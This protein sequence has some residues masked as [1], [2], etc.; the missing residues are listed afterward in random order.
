MSELSSILRMT[1][2]LSWH[3]A[4]T[5]LSSLRMVVLV[6]IMALFIIGSSWGFAEPNADLPGGI[7]ADTPYEVLF[8]TSLFILLSSTLGVVLVGFDSISRRRTSGVLAIEFCQPINRLTLGLAQLFGTW[9]A[10]CIPTFALSLVGIV[11]IDY[12]MSAWPTAS[13]LGFYFGAT[14][15]VLLWYASIQLLASS[16]ARDIGSAVTLGVGT[17]LLFTMVWLL[18]TVVAASLFGVDATNTSDAGFE[19]FAANVDL[20]SPNGVYQLLLE[21]KLDD[22]LSRPMQNWLLS[23]SVIIWTLVPSG[24]FLWRYSKLIP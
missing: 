19:A 11:L 22:D 12:Q 10:I 24:A 4:R 15:L 2:K 1:V 7:N 23:A 18:V 17:W 6:P 5:S 21:S 8:L 14:A 20:F 9:A 3:E 13:E 16:L